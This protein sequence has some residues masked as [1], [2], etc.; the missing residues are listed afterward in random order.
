MRRKDRAMDREYGLKIIDNSDYGV[1]SMIE[2]RDSTYS[3]PLSIVR[4]ENTL[5][6]HSAKAGKK[7]ELLED[8]SK[9]SV[10]FVGKTKIPE[11]F[12]Q[13]EL[14]EMSKDVSKGVQFISKV[15]TTEFSSAI[16][17]GQILKVEQREEKI[18]ALKLICEKYTPD[19][20][21]YFPIA[22]KA[23]LDKVNIYKIEI[24]DITS[25][26]KKYDTNNEE[27]KWGR[28]E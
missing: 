23:G 6:F 28:M 14:D 19:K 21:E 25:K 3:L 17:N 15:F 1:V 2:N 12:S 27:M 8:S 24:S 18:K 26:R 4:D 11:N 10:V 7:V 5:Y 9:V 20:M 22:I 16:V 13:K